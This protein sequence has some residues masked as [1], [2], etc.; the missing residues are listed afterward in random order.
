MSA[1]QKAPLEGVPPI[2]VGEMMSG[3]FFPILFDPQDVF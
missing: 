3:Q 1:S 2:P